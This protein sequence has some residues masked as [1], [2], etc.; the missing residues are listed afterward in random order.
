MIDFSTIKKTELEKDNNQEELVL[1]KPGKHIVTIKAAKYN[2]P[3]GKTPFLLILLEKESGEKHFERFYL[4]EKSLGRLQE[5]H[6]VCFNKDLSAS[7]QNLEEVA[8]YFIHSLTES[9]I[10]IG[11]VIGGEI[12]NGKLYTKMPYGY[13]G[14]NF[15]GF[16]EETFE[17]ESPKYSAFVKTINTEEVVKPKESKPEEVKTTDDLPF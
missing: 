9:P 1:I 6:Q 7:F 10:K 17:E 12:V 8:N 11:V 16:Q 5:L 15:I 13:F 2:K 4:T 14:Y 3:E